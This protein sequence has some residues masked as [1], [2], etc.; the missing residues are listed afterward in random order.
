MYLEDIRD[1]CRKVRQYTCG[2]TRDGFEDDS[3]RLDAVVRNLEVIGEA[4]RQL[5][6]E[7]RRA[8]PPHPWS[9]IIGM[10]N[11]LAHGHFGVDPDIVWSVATTRIEALAAD[12]CAYLDAQEDR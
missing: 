9:D 5:P 11:V 6:D 1:A 3:M 8:L 10:R 7:I 2:V 4:A 12:V